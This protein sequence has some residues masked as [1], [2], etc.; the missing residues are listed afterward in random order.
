[1]RKVIVKSI[2]ANQRVDKY[3]RKYLEMAP[4][5][6][7]YKLF[8]KK[9]I[10]VNNKKVSIDYILKENDEITIYVDENDLQSFLKPNVLKKEKIDFDIIYE[11]NNILIINKPS[12]IIIHEDNNPY[13][14]TINNQVLNYLYSKNEYTEDSLF[15]PSAVH[16]LDRNTSGILMIA[17]NIKTSQELYDI[18]KHKELI[19]KKYLTMVHGKIEN[20]GEIKAKLKKDSKKNIVMIDDLN[21]LSAHTIYKPLAVNEEYTLLEVQILT[22]RTHQIRAHMSYLNHPL[23]NDNKY[24]NYK[25]NETFKQKYKYKQQILHARS[26]AFKTL[27][28]NLSYLSNK[29][30][31]APL[32]NELNKIIKLEFNLEI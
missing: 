1:M 7:I 2:D 21:G 15:K 28:G 16:R 23:V 20:K 3:I 27:K 14:K 6:F 4:L 5:S 32:P 9:D 31:Y 13:S 22:G 11:D 26:I 19:E 12:G 17:K 24:G 30:F 10:K 18:L 8:R 29:I 25:N